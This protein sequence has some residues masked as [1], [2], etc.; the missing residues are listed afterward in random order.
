MVAWFVLFNDYLYK[1]VVFHCHQLNDHV[2][3]MRFEYSEAVKKTNTKRLICQWL[4]LASRI[5]VILLLGII[6]I[7]IWLASTGLTF[8]PMCHA[9]LKYSKLSFKFNN[10][11]VEGRV[12]KGEEEGE[13]SRFFQAN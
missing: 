7:Y 12:E 6:Y 2:L 11:G 8:F 3:N 4:Y 13:S 10:C 9:S 5:W 1:W